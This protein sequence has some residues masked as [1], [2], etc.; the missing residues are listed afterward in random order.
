VIPGRRLCSNVCEQRKEERIT[1]TVK[2]IQTGKGIWDV[3]I[4]QAV[5]IATLQ[6]SQDEV[7]RFQLGADLVRAM[8]VS[9][10]WANLGVN[11]SMWWLV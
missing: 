7:S 6:R 9:G 3:S 4:L 1:A 11:A 2:P 8:Y 5:N 10:P